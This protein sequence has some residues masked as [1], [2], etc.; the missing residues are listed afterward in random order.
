VSDHVDYQPYVGERHPAGSGDADTAAGGGRRSYVPLFGRIVL[1][2]LAVLLVACFVIYVVVTPA[3][4]SK[5]ATDEALVVTLC[6]VTLVNLVLVRRVVVPLQQLTLFARRFD[7]VEPG[8]RFPGAGERSEAGELALTFNEMLERLEHERAES[9]RSVLAAHEGERLRVAQELHDEVGQT[10]T[11]VLLQLSRVHGRLDGE[12]G[13]VLGEAQDAVRDSLEDVRRIATELR[14]ETLAE[15][16]LVSALAT[17]SENFSR[18]TGI[19]VEQDLQPDLPALPEETELAVYRVA[20]E[21]LTNVAR[22]ADADRTELRLLDGATELT[23]VVR[24][25]G[26]G[27]PGPRVDGNGIRGMRERAGAIGGRVRVGAPP[28]GP[29]SEVRLEVPLTR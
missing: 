16:G 10:L 7:P 5:L 15:L 2:N 23:L 18:R 8:T 6:L 24:D 17:L 13:P 26:R 3:R 29:G 25:Y 22:H 14:P 9:A 27:L 28:E 11:A 4:L 1:A 19:L 21:A 20:Q 12:L